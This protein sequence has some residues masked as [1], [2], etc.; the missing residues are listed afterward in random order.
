[1]INASLATLIR[2]SQLVHLVVVVTLSLG[3]VSAFATE[4]SSGNDIHS[5]AKHL[6]VA[7]CANSVCHGRAVAVE[8]GN[9]M[10]NEY[11]TWAKYDHHSRAYAILKNADSKRIAANMG[12]SDPTKEPAC[13]ACHADTTPANLQGEKFQ[14]SDGIGCEVCHGGAE[15]WIDSHYGNNTNADAAALHQ[16]N[17]KNGLL[18]TENPSFTATLCQS[19]HLGNTNQLANHEMMAAGHPRL[20]FEL[21]TWLALMPAHHREDADYH[22]RGKA[23]S[24]SARWLEGRMQ[25]AQD[26]LKLL[27]KHS[28]PDGL[29]PELAV[30]DCHSCHRPMDTQI[31]RPLED[32]K[33]LPAGS[34]RIN[35]NALRTLATVVT[36][37]DQTLAKELSDAIRQLNQATV[38]SKEALQ[39]SSRNL[40]TLLKKSEHTMLTSPLSNSEQQAI[41]TALLKQGA[42]G[43][44]R[45]YADAEQLFLGLQLL[46]ANKSNS[47]VSAKRY[48][49]IFAILND[50]QNYTPSKFKAAVQKT[51][52]AATEK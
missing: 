17:L 19:C 12:I 32:K 45:D 8:H 23:S 5:E 4:M 9:I 20:R 16:A 29:F 37:R 46:S 28:M 18:P 41:T 33:L 49:D 15:K 40:A 44:V 21:D 36:V 42:S 10:Q 13:L 51:L 2:I 43:D 31:Q 24:A 48:D 27:E 7:S 11:R 47:K 22:Q 1:M 26:S 25:A 38:A 3:V 30:F 14:I 39:A 34:V 35:D 52:K 6:G 50:E